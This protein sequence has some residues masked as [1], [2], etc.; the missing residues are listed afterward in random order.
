[1]SGLKDL[2]TLM[3]LA[4]TNRREKRDKID[5]SV[6]SIDVSITGLFKDL[7][8]PFAAPTPKYLVRGYGES[9]FPEVVIVDTVEQAQRAVLFMVYGP[10]ATIGPD[11]NDDIIGTWD[12]DEISSMVLDITFEIGGITVE[13]VWQVVIP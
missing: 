4:D 1:M 7:E 13:K 9:E 2:Q 11:D 5:N 8:L 12:I 6:E 3:D 10:K